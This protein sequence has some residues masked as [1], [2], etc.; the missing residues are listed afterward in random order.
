MHVLNIQVS[1]SIATSMFV[2]T[3]YLVAHIQNSYFL[4]ILGSLDKYI[5]HP[6]LRLQSSPHTPTWYAEHFSHN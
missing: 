6:A 3:L 5:K 4:G 1:C 2:F